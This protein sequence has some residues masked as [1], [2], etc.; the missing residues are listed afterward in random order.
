M[1]LHNSLIGQGNWLFRWRSYLPVALLCLLIAILKD[2]TYPAHSERIDAVWEVVCVGVSLVGIA[3]RVLTIGHA[4][5]GTSGTNTT[6]QVADTLNTT[7]MYSIVR[8]PLYLGNLIIWFGISLFVHRWWVTALVL[9]VFWLYYERIMLAEEEFLSC[10]FGEAYAVWA[11]R[12]PAFLPDP[13]K[14]QPPA[15]PFSWRKAFKNEYKTVGGMIGVFCVLEITG[16]AFLKHRLIFDPGWVAVLA[17]GSAIYGI[18]LFLKTRTR[19]L[20]DGR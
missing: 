3:V 6:R 9:L 5:P 11:S 12:T 16:D 8:H 19:I 10:K 15:L 2:F 17:V 18:G 20:D 13:R 7:G 1:S 14:W 4:A